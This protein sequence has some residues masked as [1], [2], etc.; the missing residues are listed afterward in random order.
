[1]IRVLH[2]L[3][4]LNRGGAETMV[5]NLYR[6]IDRTKIQFDFIIHTT[7][8]C[9]Y[10]DEILQLGGKIYSVPKYCGYNHFQY[11]KSWKNFFHNHPEY[12]ILHSHVRST[13]SLYLPIAKK[14]GLI[15]IIHSH[16]T[17]CGKGLSAIV[18]KALQLP[19]RYQAN[20]FFACSFEAGQWLF[21]NKIE[22]NKNFIIIKNAI[23]SEQFSYSVEKRKII[24][25]EFNLSDSC[26]VLGH[27]GRFHE[28]KNHL[29]LLNVFSEILRENPDSALLLVGDGKLKAYID[30]LIKEMNLQGK[31]IMT[32]TR[33]D[34]STLLSGIDVFV[35]PSLFEGLP[36]V[37]IEAQASGAKCF[38]SDTIT[39]E[40]MITDRCAFLPIDNPQKWATS[41]INADL[42][43]SNTTD[44]IRNAGY[45][46]KTTSKW[47]E[48][49]YLDLGDTSL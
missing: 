19:L 40:V 46:I 5:M 20:Y 44:E 6:E 8:H 21:G 4:A 42:S 39:R 11:I 34:I 1:M 18:K 31:V 24:R 47:L 35:L 48:D 45:D 17:S 22:N 38:L 37:A 33:D 7:S 26:L 23:D 16:N 10:T 49:F 3:G 15:T 32:G 36:V 2:V 13:A 12:K 14:Y 28:Q 27:I 25:N 30:G 43:R 29:F 9:D 41:I